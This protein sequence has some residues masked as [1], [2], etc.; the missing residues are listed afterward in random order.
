[1]TGRLPTRRSVAVL[2]LLVSGSPLLIA[3][4]IHHPG[5]NGTKSPVPPEGPFA[6]VS[7]ETLPA[8]P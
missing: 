4:T 8:A 2:A 7:T 6:S 1:M 5:D 3:C